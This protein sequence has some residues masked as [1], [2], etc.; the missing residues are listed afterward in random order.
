ML[1]DQFRCSQQESARPVELGVCNLNGIRLVADRL[2]AT[3]PAVHRRQCQSPP[4]SFDHRT[5]PICVEKS[6]PDPGGKAVGQETSST[7]FWGTYVRRSEQRSGP[8][9]IRALEARC[10]IRDLDEQVDIFLAQRVAGAKLAQ[11]IDEPSEHPPV[12]AAPQYLFAMRASS[13]DESGCRGR[14][15]APGYRTGSLSW[16]RI[17]CRHSHGSAGP[18][19]CAQCRTMSPAP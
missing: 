19:E 5:K 18:S 3:E 2:H 9:A 15:G 14:I 12:T 4:A 10:A 11:D 13:P 8:E 17:P 6:H 1:V 7:R 16:P